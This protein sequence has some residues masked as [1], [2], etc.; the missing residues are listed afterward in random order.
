MC[1]V[2]KFPHKKETRKAAEDSF[3]VI[4][5]IIYCVLQIEIN[6]TPSGQS[7]SPFKLQQVELR[8]PAS[9]RGQN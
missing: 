5:T 1:S 7:S 9:Y 2:F 3:S 6:L 8:S 4:N